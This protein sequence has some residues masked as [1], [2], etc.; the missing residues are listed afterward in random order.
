MN[1]LKALLN[2]TL[3][4]NEP[5]IHRRTIQYILK[6][7]LLYPATKLVQLLSQLDFSRNLSPVDWGMD[8]FL[9]Q[10]QERLERESS[11][12]RENGD[13]SIPEKVPHPCG[14]CKEL[15]KFLAS[16]T[17][18]KL[19]WPMAKARRRHIHTIIEGLDIPVTHETRH[20]RSPHPLILTKTPA[21]F[22]RD[23]SKKK[24]ALEGLA[25]LHSFRKANDN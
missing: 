2:A 11:I 20:I 12:T 21:L 4:A 10:I 1:Q 9:L 16:S 18:Q 17:E 14:D 22:S 23:E 6:H 25:L 8:Q 24:A 3:V 19:I 5:D 13:W 15:E 7:P